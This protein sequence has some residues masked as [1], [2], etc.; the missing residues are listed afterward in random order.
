M[1]LGNSKSRPKRVNIILPFGP[2]YIF[3]NKKKLNMLHLI[4]AC[5]YLANH[6]FTERPH[7][8]GWNSCKVLQKDGGSIL[9]EVD[10]ITIEVSHI[11]CQSLETVPG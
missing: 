2:P 3:P 9:N 4:Y 10:G 8:K 7:L 1:L 6:N 11:F 5:Y